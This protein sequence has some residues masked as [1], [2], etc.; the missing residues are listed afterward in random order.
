M[1][2]I[3]PKLD[4]RPNVNVDRDQPRTIDAV[5]IFKVTDG[6]DVESRAVRSAKSIKDLDFLTGIVFARSGDVCHDRYYRK[7]NSKFSSV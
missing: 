7:W 6:P 4:Q 2:P 5:R 3:Y 1:P